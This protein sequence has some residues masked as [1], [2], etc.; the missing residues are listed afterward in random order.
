MRLRDPLGVIFSDEAFAALFPRRGQP[1]LS[2]WRLAL[3]TLMQYAEDLSD[4]QAADAVRSRIDWKYMLGLPLDDPGFDDSVLSEFRSRLVEGG[5]EERLLDVLLA[6]CRAQ[7]LLQG[8]GR[9]RTDATH[10]LSSVRALNRLEC[11]VETLRA[12]RNALAIAHPEWLQTRTDPEWIERYGRRADTYHLPKAQ[13]QRHAYAEAVGRDGYGLLDPLTAEIT[14]PW[15]R[16][17][18]AVETLRQ[19]WVQQFYRVGEM[20][21]WRTAREGLPPASLFINSPYDVHARYARKRSTTWVGYKV[22][23]TE[24]CDESLPHLITHVETT[25]APATDRSALA[26]VPQALQEKEVLPSLHLVDAGYVDAEALVQSRCTY[27]VDLLGPAPGDGRWQARAGKGFAAG[28]FRVD[29]DQEQATCPAG[30]P[31]VQW[32]AGV[33]PGGH[34]VVKIQFSRLDCAACAHRTN[35][36]RS[37]HAPR[38]IT[39][40]AREAYEALRSAR[41]READ[42]EFAHEYGQRAGIEGTLSQGAR[43]FHLRQARYVGRAKTHLQQVATAAAINLVHLAAWLAGEA[44]ARTRQSAFVRLMP[45]PA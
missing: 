37:A 39:V 29:W 38:T 31:S 36:T 25:P 14:P 41:A 10:V 18:P 42:A 2:P 11:V 15:L 8:R 33:D 6:H 43:A 12:A 1:A 5:A 22:H 34:P 19:V 32:S 23:L 4:R 3:V 35:C 7:K 28:D 26:G 21:H 17:L 27:A 20:G 45:Q 30:K 13:A 9:Q 44:P 16:E 40:R 24:T